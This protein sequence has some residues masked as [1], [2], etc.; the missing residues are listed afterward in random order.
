MH[1]NFD[2]N[3]FCKRTDIDSF[4]KEVITA[5]YFLQRS[6]P[7]KSLSHQYI[8]YNK[9]LIFQK[10]P[11]Y[12]KTLL[13]AG[14]L[15]VH[16]LYDNEGNVLKFEIL[17]NC[18]VLDFVKWYNMMS[19]IQKQKLKICKTQTKDPISLQFSYNSEEYE[20]QYSNSRL[21][22]CCIRDNIIGSSVIKPRCWVYFETEFDYV[23]IYKRSF[24]LFTDTTSRIFQYKFLNNLLVN[25]FWLKKWG[26]EENDQCLFC[27]IDSETQIHIFWECPRVQN[28]WQQVKDWLVSKS[29][30]VNLSIETIFYGHE[31]EEDIV[32]MA[33]ILA[34]QYIHYQRSKKSML[35]INGFINFVASYIKMEYYSAEK[36]N[37][38]VNYMH[39][40]EKFI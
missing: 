4:Y 5:W 3:W 16:D 34:K 7:T 17:R 40:W 32:N 21:L 35:N 36:S 6:T 20:F 27:T 15:K 14:I 22:Y 8:Y 26:I 28:F 19:V 12:W 33:L 38:V 10:Q 25:K 24:Q 39:K 23:E 2:I 9:E 30:K 11:F 18:G 13:Q 29:L 31:K 37:K 1:R